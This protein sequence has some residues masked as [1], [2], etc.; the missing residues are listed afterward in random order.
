MHYLICFGKIDTLELNPN[1]YSWK[2]GELVF[3]FTITLGRKML[4]DSKPKINVVEYMWL[5]YFLLLSN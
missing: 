4:R 2:G 5:G 1:A 3:S